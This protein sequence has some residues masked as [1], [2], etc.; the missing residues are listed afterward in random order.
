[1]LPPNKF[2][3]LGNHQLRLSQLAWQGECKWFAE[4]ASYQIAFSTLRQDDRPICPVDLMDNGRV[5][6]RP[7]RDS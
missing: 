6:I 2:P 4:V 7:S 1:M 5:G 3:S